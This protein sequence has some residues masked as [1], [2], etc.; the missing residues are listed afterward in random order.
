MISGAGPRFSVIISV[1][2]EAM[3]VSMVSPGPKAMANSRFPDPRSSCINSRST[4]RM[5]GDDM[6]P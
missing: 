2:L 5:V 6:F 1:Q 4:N 3:K